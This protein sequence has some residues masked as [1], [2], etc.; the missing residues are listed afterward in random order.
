MWRAMTELDP[1]A[2]MRY[3]L[4][5]IRALV[6]KPRAD[7]TS[8]ELTIYTFASAALAGGDPVIASVERM[9]RRL[10]RVC[11]AEWAPN[12]PADHIS[13]CAAAAISDIA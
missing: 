2:W 6:D 7:M 12:L 10:C 5:Q 11:G 9:G 13:G 3:A 8:D 4:G 1:Q